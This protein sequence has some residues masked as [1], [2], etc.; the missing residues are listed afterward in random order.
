MRQITGTIKSTPN[1]WLPVLYNIAPPNTRRMATL[2]TQ[3]A[4]CQSNP[5]LPINADIEEL[6]RIRQQRLK[7]RQPPVRTAGTSGRA[8]RSEIPTSSRILQANQMDS[9]YP[10]D[11]LL[12]LNPPS[13]AGGW[14][15]QLRYI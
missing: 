5:T 14:R 2:K 9:I 6:T 8:K 10:A 7:S 11:N 13:S 3:V 1:A 4:K 15:C 12:L